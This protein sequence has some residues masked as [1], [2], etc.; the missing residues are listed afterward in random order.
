VTDLK[1]TK[2]R[3][4]LLGIW[5]IPLWAVTALL[6]HWVMWTLDLW[7]LVIRLPLAWIM[8]VKVPIGI[9]WVIA[10]RELPA[11]PVPDQAKEKGK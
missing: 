10:N 2:L 5:I 1:P 7:W 11:P 8:L 4:W 3:L 6:L 9:G